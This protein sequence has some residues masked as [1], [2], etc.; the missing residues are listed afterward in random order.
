MSLLISKFVKKSHAQ[1]RIYFIFL[2]KVLKQNLNCFIPNLHFSE[3]I[4][5]AVI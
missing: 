3:K 1:A 2:K 5:N 4:E